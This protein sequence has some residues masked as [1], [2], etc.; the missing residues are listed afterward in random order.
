MTFVRHN[1]FYHSKVYDI[2]YAPR[3]ILCLYNKYHMSRKSQT[4]L[5]SELEGIIWLFRKKYFFLDFGNHTLEQNMEV[6][7]ATQLRLAKEESKH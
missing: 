4:D 3:Y 7:H 1:Y 6:F 2:C 5:Y